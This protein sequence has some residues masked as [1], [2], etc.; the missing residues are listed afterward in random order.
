[1]QNEFLLIDDNIPSFVS[2]APA[3]SAKKSRAFAMMRGLLPQAT[4]LPES[5]SVS[6]LEQSRP[7]PMAQEHKTD[8]ATVSQHLE[9][10][11][12]TDR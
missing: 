10:P 9:I 8:T 11:A 7:P 2:G 6:R 3:D 1:M 5:K 12:T 4:Q